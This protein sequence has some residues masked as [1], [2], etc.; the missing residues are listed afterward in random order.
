MKTITIEVEDNYWLEILNLIKTFPIKIIEE[1]NTDSTLKIPHKTP[2][3]EG[4]KILAILQK[5]GFL[6]SMPDVANLSEN[7]KDYLDW[8]DKT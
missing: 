5:T 8:S 2:S 4:E 6:G 3:T 7:Y 1:K